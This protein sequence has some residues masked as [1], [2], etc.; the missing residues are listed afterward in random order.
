MDNSVY[1][2]LSRQV[3]AQ[4]QLGVIANNIA[5]A[6]TTG[7]KS[8]A[9]LFQEYLV[10]DADSRDT[11]YV[12]DR[13]TIRDTSGGSLK[14][15]GNPLDVALEGPGYF[16]VLSD[17]GEQLYT[18]AG[19]FTVNTEG[20]LSTVD[21]DPVLSATGT[22]IQFAETDNNIVISADGRIEVDGAERDSLGV[23]QF[24]NE[25]DLLPLSGTLF[26]SEEIDPIASAVDTRIAQG[27]VEKSN[28]NSIAQTTELIKM[29]RAYEG[30]SSFISGLYEMQEDAI[31]RIARQ[32]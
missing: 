27:F 29:Q 5:N 17:T 10:G 30:T 24:E 28:V 2:A 32:N 9:M 6:N 31:R 21:G 18:R 4:R 3:S 20:T 23:F 12:Q 16:A 7:F 22:E 11:A 14:Q 26:S 13:A 8:E 1:V 19:N 25:Q 15:T